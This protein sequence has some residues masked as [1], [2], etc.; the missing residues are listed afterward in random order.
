MTLRDTYIP[1]VKTRW[2]IEEQER[3]RLAP[4]FP[5]V[6]ASDLHGPTADYKLSNRV[7][8]ANPMRWNALLQEWLFE[9]GKVPRPDDFY[10]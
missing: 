7:A 8:L 1:K 5:N 2:S 9:S 10:R 3:C 4:Q 6:K